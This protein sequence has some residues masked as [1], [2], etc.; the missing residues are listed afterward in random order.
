VEVPGLGYT[1][2]GEGAE[3]YAVVVL[4]GRAEMFV[5]TSLELSFYQNVNYDRVAATGTH[6]AYLPENAIKDG[7]RRGAAL[8]RTSRAPEKEGEE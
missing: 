5:G 2:V 1:K 4:C 8:C 7:R 3:T 6:F